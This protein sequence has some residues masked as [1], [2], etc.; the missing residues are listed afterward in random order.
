MVQLLVMKRIFTVNHGF[1]DE[2]PQAIFT[3]DF[4][5]GA[6][7][8]TV[9]S[10][11]PGSTVVIENGTGIYGSKCVKISSSVFPILHIQSK[12]AALRSVKNTG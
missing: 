3:E 5:N 6:N 9:V 11:D 10:S 8:W 7:G 12:S 4:E 1:I 2:V